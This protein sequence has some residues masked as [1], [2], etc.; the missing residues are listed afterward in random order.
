MTCSVHNLLC[1]IEVSVCFKFNGRFVKSIEL[2]VL[3][4]DPTM[5]LV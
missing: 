2:T 5:S 1:I 3:D 4:S